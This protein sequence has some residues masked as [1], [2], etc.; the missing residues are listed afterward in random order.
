MEEQP[1]SQPEPQ[2]N[3]RGALMFGAGIIVVA[4]VLV[5]LFMFAGKG[6]SACDQWEEAKTEW[7]SSFPP[8]QRQT[9]ADLANFQGYVDLNGERVTRPE[10]C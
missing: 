4:V 3:K 9:N 1:G 2:T 8:I 5:V 10:G 6:D 7:V